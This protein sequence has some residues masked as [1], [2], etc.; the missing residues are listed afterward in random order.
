MN[1][2]IFPLLQ[3]APPKS[4]SILIILYIEAIGD[5]TILDFEKCS[6]IH[7]CEGSMRTLIGVS[8]IWKTTSKTKVFFTL[9]NV[10]FS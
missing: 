4:A 2:E 6:Y 1:I 8:L 3:R 10:L 5:C 7:L 9:T